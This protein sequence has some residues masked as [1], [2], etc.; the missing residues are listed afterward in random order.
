VARDDAPPT[1]A[2]RRRCA[3]CRRA[4]QAPSGPLV[5][6]ASEPLGEGIAAWEEAFLQPMRGVRRCCCWRLTC[7]ARCRSA[8]CCGGMARVVRRRCAGADR[9]AWRCAGRRRGTGDAAVGHQRRSLED[10]AAAAARQVLDWRRD[11][12]ESIALVALDRLTAR[13]VRA[14]LERAQVAV[15]DETGWKLSTTSAAAALMRWYDLVADDLYWRDLLDWLKSGFTLAGRPNKAREVAF[16]ERAIRAGGALQGAGA[17]RRALADYAAARTRAGHRS[18][19]RRPDPRF[20]HRATAGHAAPDRRSARICARSMRCSMR[21]ACARTWRP[22]RSAAACCAR[23]NCSPPRW[24]ASVAA[25]RWPNSARCWPRASRRRV[26]HRHPVDSP[27]VMVSLAATTLRPFDAALLIGADAQ[28]LPAAAGELLFMS[29]AVRAELGLATAE[30]E[31]RAQA[32][33][34]AALLA[35]VPRWRRPGAGSA[36]TSRIRCRRCCSGC[37]W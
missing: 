21:W 16:F 20:D 14:L 13:R 19:R 27:V 28:H 22:T 32:A 7:Q 34:L 37:S 5:F 4:P 10:E 3:N 23:S 35:D 17:I 15:L 25:R 2:R 9:A 8:R 24:P 6:L 31:L 26:V 36:A 1:T 12:V 30:R 11:G 33:Q 29:N 18:R